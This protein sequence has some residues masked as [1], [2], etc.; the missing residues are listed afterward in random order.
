MKRFTLAAV[1][2]LAL[3]PFADSFDQFALQG[4]RFP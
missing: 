1:L 3:P 2:L 4:S